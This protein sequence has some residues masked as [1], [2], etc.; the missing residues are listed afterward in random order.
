MTIIVTEPPVPPQPV[1]VLPEQKFASPY[2]SSRES[3]RS[4]AAMYIGRAFPTLF[5]DPWHHVDEVL[6]SEHFAKVLDELQNHMTDAVLDLPSW[7]KL[8]QRESEVY[9][10]E[11]YKYRMRQFITKY[12]NLFPDPMVLHSRY[13]RAF[14]FI[15]DLKKVIEAAQSRI[16]LIDERLQNQET[17]A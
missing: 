12:S 4:I 16:A 8:I 13:E 9:D 10:P 3:I 5:P 15:Q 14:A 1:L 2:V 7:C 17:P 11:H 6:R